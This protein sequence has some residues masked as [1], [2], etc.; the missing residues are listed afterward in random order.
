MKEFLLD[1][2]SKFIFVIWH[3]LGRQEAPTN[4]MHHGTF[5]EV[6]RSCIILYGY[7]WFKE[8]GWKLGI[9][10]AFILLFQLVVSFVGLGDSCKGQL[11]LLHQQSTSSLLQKFFF[12]YSLQISKTNFKGLNFKPACDHLQPNNHGTW[13]L[14]SFWMRNNP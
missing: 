14:F 6:L 10:G 5:I 11:W 8:L 4:W 12:L 2:I 13:E 3:I 1:C 9:K 7:F